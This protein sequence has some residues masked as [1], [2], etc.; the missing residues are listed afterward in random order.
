[1]GEEE[2]KDEKE[3]REEEKHEQCLE[4]FNRRG[5]R[6][7]VEDVTHCIILNTRVNDKKK[8]PASPGAWL[9]SK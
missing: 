5:R 7:E 1:M 6:V 2:G 8:C 3:N 4:F 9:I